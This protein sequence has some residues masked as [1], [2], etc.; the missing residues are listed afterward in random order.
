[1]NVPLAHNFASLIENRIVMINKRPTRNYAALKSIIILPVA[2]I[3]FVMF[4]FK[5]ESI[6]TYNGYQEPLFSKSSETEILKFLGINTGYPQEAKN[7][8]DTGWVFVVVKMNKGGII[9]ECK[10]FTDMKGI[11]V[12]FL[13]EIVIVGHKP[14]VGVSASKIEKTSSNEHLLLKTACLSA[15]NKL[16]EIKIQEWRDKDLE[17]AIPFK[18]TLK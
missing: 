6:P 16:K 7:S 15:T 17:F 2:A 9:K 1:M 18:F 3:L 4:S 13:N 11:K 8:S 10:A 12:P 14:S 5:P